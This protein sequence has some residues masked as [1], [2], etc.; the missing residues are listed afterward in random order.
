MSRI[1]DAMRRTG[2]LVGGPPA[3]DPPPFVLEEFSSDGGGRSWKPAADAT[4]V[5]LPLPAPRAAEL[6]RASSGEDVG[7]LEVAQVLYRRWWVIGVTVTASLAAAALYNYLATPIY[8]ARVRLLIQ[9]DSS[10]IVPFRPLVADDAR[11]D[12]TQIEVLQSRALARN[13]LES[14]KLL[15]G[16]ATS[17]SNQISAFVG[18]LRVAPVANT[19]VVNLSFQSTDAEHAARM[20]NGLAQ[21]YIDKNREDRLQRTREAAVW[22]NDRLADLRHQ[23]EASQRA[24]QDYREEKDAVSLEDRQNIV[25]Q[26]LAQLNTSVTAVRTERVEKQAL[27]D[28]LVRLQESGRPLDTFPPILSNNFIQGLKADLAAL[29]RER[30]QQAERL[31]HLH[32][33]MV[34]LDTAIASAE[35]RLEAEMAK[36][37]EGIQNEFRSARAREQA[38]V[39][40]LEDQKRE[41][42]ELNQ[43]SIGYSAL[44]RD[45]ASTQQILDGVLQRLKEAELSTQ[46]EGDH[47]RILDAAEVPRF[48]IWPRTRLNLIIALFGGT[49]VAIGLALGLEYL[50]PRVVGPDHVGTVMGL[51]VLGVAPR[52][53]ALKDGPEII[54]GLPPVF[55]EAVRGIRARI[56]LSPAA[57]G[58]R[59]LVVTSANPGEGKTVVASNLAIS[60]AMSGRKVL[61]IDGDLRRPQI[62]RVFNLSRSPGLVNVMIGD[63]KPSEALRESAVKGLSVLTAGAE[64]GSSPDLLLTDRL[65]QV[66]QG[67]T[68]AFDLVVVDSPP[69][70]AVADASII[71]NAA[72][73]VVFV[74]GA[75][76][77]NREVVENALER[78]SAVQAHVIGVVMNKAT[79]DTSVDYYY[80]YDP[81]D[82]HDVLSRV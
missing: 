37:V 73:A 31:G 82:E 44:Q 63:V 10:Q 8:E 75:G 79:V 50:N 52:V 80:G 74:V 7:I 56:L 55:Q 41:V 12:I 36:I 78:L 68:A 38:L 60:M 11:G 71:A 22:L 23:V 28:Q 15:D 29:Q 45:A 58:A 51:S 72:S 49:I 66:I 27:Y 33:E 64:S 32:P 25:I 62:H 39:A 17:E 13:V 70:M 46:M 65:R 1:S 42:L 76:A 2:R 20:V 5:A 24:L 14:L 16:D 59:T 18:S 54:K 77:T 34:R 19:R 21:V 35:Q 69:V 26:E 4:P 3:D 61:L 81:V 48:A 43:K 53:A 6:G 47:A 30:L 40:T 67:F 9:P 57:A